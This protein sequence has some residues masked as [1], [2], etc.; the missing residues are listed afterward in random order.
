MDTSD[1]S[2]PIVEDRIRQ[3]FDTLTE[4]Q[5]RVA[6][7][8]LN[9]VATAA[10]LPSARLAEASGVSQSTVVRL[11]TALGYSG[12]PEMQQAFQ[13]RLLGRIDTV[14]RFEYAQHGM[15]QLL[16]ESPEQLLEGEVPLFH[17]VFHADMR[18]MEQAL[19]MLSPEA[20]EAAI[21]AILTARQRYI[22]GLRGSAP[23]ALALGIGL[24]QIFHDT[25]ILGQGVGDLADELF[26]LGSDDLLIAFSYTRYMA[27]TIRCLQLARE[28]GA[29]SIAITD[30]LV[31]PAARLAQVV[32]VTPNP[33]WFMQLSAAPLS[34]VNALLLEVM[35]RTRDQAVESLEH[36]DAILSAFE[37]FRLDTERELP[38]AQG[39]S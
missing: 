18:N 23:F 26:G 3:Q 38:F 8:L 35:L 15:E 29:A 10:Y 7:Y 39:T 28:V 16:T 20:F 4:G 2:A 22:V 14:S 33:L 21:Q 17:K 34:L 36:V 32:L 30:S 5:K 19:R 12:F 13:E 1:T 9:N 24:R 6:E 31:S 37:V 27:E 11:A 25:L